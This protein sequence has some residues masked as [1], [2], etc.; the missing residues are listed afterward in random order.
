MVCP[1]CGKEAAEGA[2][3]CTGCGGRLDNLP[4]NEKAAAETNDSNTDITESAENAAE[5]AV[6][7]DSADEQRSVSDANENVSAA[8]E[9]QKSSE[10][11]DN[12]QRMA[13]PYIYNPNNFA[14]PFSVSAR[15]ADANAQ[16][17]SEDAA[18]V[19][20]QP[21]DSATDSAN[22]PP[23][24]PLST[25]SFIW[26]KLLFLIPIVNIIVLFV[27]AFAEGINKNS[28]S[29]A[30]AALIGLLAVALITAAGAV[31][32][33]VYSNEI[34]SWLQSLIEQLMRMAA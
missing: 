13:N 6:E 2:L 9:E 20:P 16:L 1:N 29:Y 10:S 25:W 7:T 22:Q 31:L 28:R 11:A 17:G 5:A 15:N 8:I 23:V 34:I 24:K 4:K 32:C 19:E 14:Q 12:T 33:V 27:F 3:F 18:E 30:R 26:R 21:T